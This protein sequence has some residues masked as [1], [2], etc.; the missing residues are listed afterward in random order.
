MP[1]K[2]TFQQSYWLARIIPIFAQAASATGP[3]ARPGVQM[4]LRLSLHLSLALDCAATAQI[5]YSAPI[6]PTISDL[7]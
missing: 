7:S 3:R 5:Q 4:V 2:N 6:K 1:A